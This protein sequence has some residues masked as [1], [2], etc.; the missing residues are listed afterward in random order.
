MPSTIRSTSVITRSS[1]PSIGRRIAAAVIALAAS[2][3]L[4]IGVDPFG[5]IA[6]APEAT[7]ALGLIATEAIAA[8]LLV[9]PMV[10]FVF[11]LVAA[12]R[13]SAPFGSGGSSDVG[14]PLEV[15]WTADG[16]SDGG[17]G[18]GSDGSS[19]DGGGGDGGGGGD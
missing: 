10:G 3:G 11:D 15:W 13:G 14:G 8:F 12:W 18:G 9:Y 7:A 19:S 17:G 5:L 4:A 16:A 1:R 2:V 6:D